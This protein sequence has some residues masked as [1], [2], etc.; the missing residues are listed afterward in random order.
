MPG[1]Q[2]RFRSIPGSAIADLQIFEFE[3]VFVPGRISALDLEPDRNVAKGVFIECNAG[4]LVFEIIDDLQ[5]RHTLAGAREVLRPRR[6]SGESGCVAACLSITLT[7]RKPRQGGEPF[8]SIDDWRRGMVDAATRFQEAV[9]LVEGGALAEAD[10]ICLEILSQSPIDSQTMFLRGLI[11]FQQGE[12]DRAV[13]LIR[14][15]SENDPNN[16][17]YLAT[18]GAMLIDTGDVPE[19]MIALER[20][21]ALNADDAVSLRHLAR[22]YR[23]AGR[24]SDA[25]AALEHLALR[26]PPELT[27]LHAHGDLLQAV[28]GPDAAVM[29]FERMVAMAPGDVL[30]RN[31][32]AAC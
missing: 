23:Q 4:L 2:R 18:L 11:A 30:A 20:A 17:S 9:R 25:I 8:G 14:S 27:D 10:A 31:L 28:R 29:I 6:R 24:V 16:S 1:H 21:L 7:I 32:L 12:A 15:A 26:E 13:G 3:K 5:Q 22:L 19:A